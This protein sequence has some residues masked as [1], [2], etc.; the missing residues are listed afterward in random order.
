MAIT[1]CQAGI[2]QYPQYP[3][4]SHSAID[5]YAY[6]KYKFNYGVKDPYTG[7]NKSQYEERDGDKVR[8]KFLEI[9]ILSEIG[10]RTF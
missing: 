1:I 5:Y 10:S 9:Y 8:G 6:P 4:N 2:I 7:D 3:A